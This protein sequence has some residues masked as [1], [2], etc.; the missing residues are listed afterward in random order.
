MLGSDKFRETKAQLEQDW[1]LEDFQEAHVF[2]DL[3][4]DTQTLLDQRLNPQK[5]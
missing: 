3:Q 2:L 1:S 4:E 5:G